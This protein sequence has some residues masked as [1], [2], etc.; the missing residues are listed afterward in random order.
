MRHCRLEKTD[1][2]ETAMNRVVLP[3]KD[4]AI[5]L[6]RN[7]QLIRA[8]EEQV[9][10]LFVGGMIPG[11]VHLCAGQEAVAVD[12]SVMRVGGANVPIPFSKS[13]ES[14]ILPDAPKLAAIVAELLHGTR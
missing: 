13:I 7:M 10:S 4:E 8:F 2:D 9:R 14:L 12:A 5:L 6:L 3:P 11:L 1:A